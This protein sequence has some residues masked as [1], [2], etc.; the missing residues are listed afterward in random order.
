MNNNVEKV[1]TCDCTQLPAEFV[2]DLHLHVEELLGGD[3][4]VGVDHQLVHAQRINLAE[5]RGQEEAGGSHELELGL[6]DAVAAQH[7][8]KVLDGEQKNLA[9]VVKYKCCKSNNFLFLKSAYEP[10][11]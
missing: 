1:Q 2:Q 11:K 4:A 8:V 10:S 5:F 7:T 9:E 3:G 6:E